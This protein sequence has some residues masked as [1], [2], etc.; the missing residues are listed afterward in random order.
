M[1]VGV[2]SIMVS[3]LSRVVNILKTP[4]IESINR[5]NSYGG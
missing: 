2:F 4:S 3:L 1:D 5:V